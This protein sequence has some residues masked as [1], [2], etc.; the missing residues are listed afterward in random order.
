MKPSS[1][2]RPI[3]TPE[4]HHIRDRPEGDNIEIR[5][6]VERAIWK[7]AALAQFGAQRDHDVERQPR[8]T[9][10]F[11]G[12]RTIF[13]VRIDHGQSARQFRRRLVMVDD[14]DI[15]PE[16]AGGGDFDGVGNPAIHGHD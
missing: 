1:Q 16:L 12:K 9:K 13:S 6:N 4:R 5:S 11:I 14:D 8:G 2:Q 7:P 10:S 3:D 15:Q